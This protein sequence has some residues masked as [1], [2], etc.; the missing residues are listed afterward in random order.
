MLCLPLKGIQSIHEPTV[1]VDGSHAVGSSIIF[2]ELVQQ[3][4]LILKCFVL[5]V[6]QGWSLEILTRVE[7]ILNQVVLSV[8][9][10]QPDDPLNTVQGRSCATCL[11][12][13]TSSG[14]K[15]RTLRQNIGVYISIRTGGN[16][17]TFG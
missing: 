12:D 2:K 9:L 6:L 10:H 11:E 5:L 14:H 16:N 1:L 3:I 17:F 7:D 4:D 15:Q 13:H 8:L